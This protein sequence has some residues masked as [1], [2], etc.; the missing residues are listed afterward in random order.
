MCLVSNPFNRRK[1]RFSDPAVSG[2]YWRYSSVLPAYSSESGFHR[3]NS[4]LMGRR[5]MKTNGDEKETHLAETTATYALGVFCQLVNPYISGV[6]H[7]KK[8]FMKDFFDAVLEGD[9]LSDPPSRHHRT[10]KPGKTTITAGVWAGINETDLTRFY[11]G[12]KK[13]PSWKATE[14]YQHLDVSEVERLC[15]DISVDALAD[16]QK[17]LIKANIKVSDISELPSATGKWLLSVLKANA[18]G[19]DILVD[20]IGF[21]PEFDMFENLPLASGHISNGRL[22]LGRSS[23]PWE[24]YPIPPDKPDDHLEK[25]YLTQMQAAY[26]DHL[27]KPINCSDDLPQTCRPEYAKQRKYFY[28]AEGMRRNLRDV[29]ENGEQ[30]FD[31]LKVDLYDGICDI[32]ASDYA[33]GLL[34]MRATLSQAA[35]FPLS[36]SA[37]A[38]FPSMIKA[39][40]KKGLCHML[41]NDHKLEWV[42]GDE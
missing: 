41:V 23:V 38:Q 26:A 14:F 11:N 8:G 15:G 19:R 5:R 10:R 2:V 34:R 31:A 3:R 12:S 18:D 32:C 17:E 22:H 6:D 39:A 4:D 42:Q 29:I 24:T 21:Q 36:G 40:E 16:F 27:H 20:G 13:I 30:E 7:H 1:L 9:I 33:D 28:D 25:T 35:G 37:I